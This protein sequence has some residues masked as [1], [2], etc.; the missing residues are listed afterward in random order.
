MREHATDTGVRVQGEWTGSGLSS[1]KIYDNVDHERNWS[2]SPSNICCIHID[3]FYQ[4]NLY[5]TMQT[6]HEILDIIEA[7]LRMST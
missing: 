1:D 3:V 5:K 4:S 7:S 2:T 6:F